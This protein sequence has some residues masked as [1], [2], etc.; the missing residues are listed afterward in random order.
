MRFDYRNLATIPFK[1]LTLGWLAVPPPYAT[2]KFHELLRRLHDFYFPA[3]R[4]PASLSS[5]WNL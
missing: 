3:F 5:M 1:S 2:A 4:L